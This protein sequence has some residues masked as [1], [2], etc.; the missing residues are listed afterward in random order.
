MRT[1]G[2]RPHV[3]NLPALDQKDEPG[4]TEL[5]EVVGA[6]LDNIGPH[7]V[8]TGLPGPTLGVDEAL[9]HLCD[10]WPVFSLQD[11]EGWVVLGFG[12]AAPTYFV[13]DE[14]TATLT[15]REPGVEPV[16]VGDLR[17]TEFS[18]LPIPALRAQGRRMAR[19]EGPLVTFYGQPAWGYRGYPETLKVLARAARSTPELNFL[20]RPHPKETDA[21][22]NAVHAMFEAEG[23]VLARCP[24]TTIEMSLA[25]AD[26]VLSV[27]STVGQDHVA[28]QRYSPE[29][30]GAA[31]YLL[32][33]PAIRSLLAA[34]T[35]S[36]MPRVVRDGL[37]DSAG[38]ADD[39]ISL[40]RRLTAPS[41]AMTSWRK[42]GE[43][44]P[45]PG[46]IAGVVADHIVARLASR[47][48]LELCPR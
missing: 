29:P 17:S 10:D 11:Y 21:E 14:H 31:A 6:L 8:I 3:V 44:L 12:R 22:R 4:R 5:F 18:D 27:F 34:D 47:L 7:A 16:V 28:L 38:S 37:A 40:L 9:V 13:S 39:V 36:D 48:N 41:A 35:G 30:I 15:L 32:F 19:T 42:I 26:A 45:A 1:A 46:G 2:L 24:A 23:V 25:M 20:Y 43:A 33:D